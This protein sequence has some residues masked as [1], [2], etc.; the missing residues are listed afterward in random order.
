MA[1]SNLLLT[2]LFLTNPFKIRTAIAK[3]SPLNYLLI[4]DYSSL[5]IQTI[6]VEHPDLLSPTPFQCSC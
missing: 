3:Q 5:I 1:E 4:T 6:P 2:E